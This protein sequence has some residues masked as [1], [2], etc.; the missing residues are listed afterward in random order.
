MAES[1][2]EVQ[3]TIRLTRFL[4]HRNPTMMLSNLD[5]V[6]SWSAQRIY[7]ISAFQMFEYMATVRPDRMM[8]SFGALRANN[9]ENA[10]TTGNV[11]MQ[12]P[13][14]RIPQQVHV[15]AG[16][17]GFNAN[18]GART[19]DFPYQIGMLQSSNIVTSI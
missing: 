13:P 14:E 17:E 19:Q 6:F 9:L 5:D 2:N 4:I 16:F 11:R 1:I 7:W 12:C 18:S 3:D 8:V 15:Q 10:K